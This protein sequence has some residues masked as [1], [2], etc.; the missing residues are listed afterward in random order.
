MAEPDR[1]V[2]VMVGDGSYLMM[3]SEIATSVDAGREAHHRA[4]STT[5]ASAAST[6]CSSATGGAQL[7]QSAG[8]RG[9]RRCRDRFRRARRAASARIAEKGRAHRRARRR[10]GGGR[11]RPSAPRSIVIETDPVASHRGRRP[12]VGRGGAGGVASG[13]RC[14]RRAR[15]YDAARADSDGATEHERSASAPIPSAGPTTTC[16]SSAATPARDLPAE[17]RRDRLRGH[18]ARAT[19]SRA[20]RR[21]CEAALA[22]IRPGLRRRGWYSARPAAAAMRD[23]EIDGAA[24]A[25]ASCSR[26]WAASVL[27]V[28]RDAANAIHGDRARAAV[29]ARRR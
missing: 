20:S 11:A 29:A 16:A 13:P 24:A 28:R 8:A 7:Q 18:G 15:R 12:L 5:A 6:A 1:E 3:N 4:C 22:A 14:R 19:S 10:A 27:V 21:R 25:S 26:R 17:A 2:I 9:T 23:A